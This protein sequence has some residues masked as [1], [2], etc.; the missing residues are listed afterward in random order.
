VAGYGLADADGRDVRSEPEDAE[1]VTDVEQTGEKPA[2][3]DGPDPSPN[4]SHDILSHECGP[5]PA[6][7][8]DAS[9]QK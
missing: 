7:I 4:R 3:D 6:V 9:C 1:S 8:V 2:D 5:L